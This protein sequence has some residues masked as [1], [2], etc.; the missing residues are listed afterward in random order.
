L[1][2]AEWSLLWPEAR[3]ATPLDLSLRPCAWGSRLPRLRRI[4]PGRRRCMGRPVFRPTPN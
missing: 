4:L 3:A 2:D 1:L